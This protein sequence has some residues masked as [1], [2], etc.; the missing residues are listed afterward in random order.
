MSDDNKSIDANEI[1]SAKG[2]LEHVETEAKKANVKPVF[3]CESCGETQDI[4]ENLLA[5]MEAD[6]D[7][8]SEI[9]SHCDST[10]KISV[11]A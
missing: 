10:M 2:T 7:I 5:K 6:E 4:P 8:T 3:K 9:P 1:A 11:A